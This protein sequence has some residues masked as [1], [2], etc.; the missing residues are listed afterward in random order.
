MAIS[1]YGVTLKWGTS[2]ASLTKKIDIK[3]FPDMGGA[4]E[5]LETT[6]LSDPAQTYINGIQSMKA[7]EFTA[8]YTKADYQAVLTDA[9]KPL[10]YALEFG[11][12]GAEGVFEWQGEHD[13]WVTG[14]GVNAVTE[15]KISIAPSTKPTLKTT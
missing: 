15:M 1:T 2:S 9:N 6:T 8:N 10:Y 12:N 5:L 14:A 7:I 11:E 3:D 4:P 13:V